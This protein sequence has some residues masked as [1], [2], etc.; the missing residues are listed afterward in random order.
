MIGRTISHYALLETLGEG[1]MGVVYKAEDTR[2]G[3]LVAVKMI[4]E[5]LSDAGA[6]ERLKREARAASA[7]NHPNICTIY[8]IDEVDGQPFLVMEMLE[9]RTL[10]DSPPVESEKLLDTIEFAMLW[11]SRTRRTSS[12]AICRRILPHHAP[13]QTRLRPCEGA[14]NATT[15]RSATACRLTDSN[16][17]VGTIAY[18]RPSR[19]AAS[20]DYAL[21][22]R[23]RSRTGDRTK[24]FPADHRGRL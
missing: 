20:A 21:F 12:I 17:A 14:P 3:R 8:E 6:I 1:G 9:G 7:L 23:R 5:G 4:S 15:V 22:F 24:V 2:L 19:P 11:R 10:R 13:P 16:T 18:C